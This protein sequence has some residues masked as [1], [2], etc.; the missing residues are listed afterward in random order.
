MRRVESARRLPPRREVRLGAVRDTG[1]RRNPTLTVVVPPE[2]SNQMF[3]VELQRMT[4][5][6]GKQNRCEAGDFSAITG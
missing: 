3:R 6:A 1:R 4:L 2:E 5:T